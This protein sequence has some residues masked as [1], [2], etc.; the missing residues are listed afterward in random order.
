MS[1][2]CDKEAIREAYNTVRDDKSEINWAVFKYEGNLITVA[3][4]G[5]DYNDFLNSFDGIIIIIQTILLI[6]IRNLFM[7]IK[8]RF[9]AIICILKNI[10]W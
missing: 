9:S 6:T 10:Y 8:N 3:S 5:V 4:T 7:F 1:T 2:T